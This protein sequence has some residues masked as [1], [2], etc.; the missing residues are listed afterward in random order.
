MCSYG[1]YIWAGW[2]DV[3]RAFRAWVLALR[4][5]FP[6]DSEVYSINNHVS[7][8][9]LFHCR[10]LIFVRCAMIVMLWRD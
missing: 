5:T 1:T 9:L 3:W 8:Y 7:C 10:L 4:V 6:P 2:V